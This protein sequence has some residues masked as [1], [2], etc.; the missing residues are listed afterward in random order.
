MFMKSSKLKLNFVGAEILN[1]II[2]S[3]E[4]YNLDWSSVMSVLLE[5]IQNVDM[6]GKVLILIVFRNIKL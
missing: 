6:T 5:K 3:K 1:H 2:L 4:F